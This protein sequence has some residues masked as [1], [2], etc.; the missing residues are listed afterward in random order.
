MSAYI[1]QRLH[2]WAAW[3]RM[4]IDGFYGTGGTQFSYDEPM[5]VTLGYFSGPVNAR[6]LETEEAVGWLRLEERRLAACV[7][8]HYR[9]HAGWSALIKAEFL[10]V[11]TRT[12]W[13]Y[14]DK[15]HALLLEYLIDRALGIFAQTED[16]RIARRASRVFA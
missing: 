14:V 15:S 10:G 8:L 9:D 12:F 11:S 2:E 7:C 1:E 4:R 5:L 13:R 3:S 6:C 16:V